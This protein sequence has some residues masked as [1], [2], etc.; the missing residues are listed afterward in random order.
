[1]KSLPVLSCSIVFLTAGI[2][3]SAT[4][5]QA[6]EYKT[7]LSKAE[8]E[9]SLERRLE[10]WVKA[11]EAAEDE[12]KKF[13]LYGKGFSLARK[14]DNTKYISVFAK[15]LNKS[16]L[17]SPA[18]KAS[19]IFEYLSVQKKKHQPLPSKEWED[20]LAMPGTDPK[21]D[22]TARRNLADAYHRDSQW[23]KEIALLKKLVK[24]P[25]ADD[26]KKQDILFNLSQV[27]LAMNRMDDA[28]AC[29]KDVLRIKSL[30]P[31]RRAK[32]HL[33]IASALVH[34][35]GWHSV[36]S[37]ERYKQ[38]SDHCLQAMKAKDKYYYRQALISLVAGTYKIGNDEEVIR[39][40]KKYLTR[41]KKVDLP[42]WLEVKTYETR[43]LLREE[44]YPEAIEIL[45]QLY[46]SRSGPD[47]CISLGQTYYR[48]GDYT[49]ALGM[50]SEA[51]DLLK[52]DDSDRLP[53]SK[54]W[55][56][57][58]GGLVK[59]K[60]QLDALFLARAKRLN[61]EARAAGKAPVAEEREVDE[62]RPFQKKGK[63][64]EPTSLEEINKEEE[65]DLLGEGLDL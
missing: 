58:L 42:T 55:C 31:N 32:V 52:G 40:S 49:A 51:V 26:F 24:H 45:E 17:A 23:Y 59:I 27:Y 44:R 2:F 53:R 4:G 48:N 7:L 14:I 12:S 63:K 39:L 29:L 5:L 54:S 11:A 10:L 16:P 15:L 3:F 61:A 22:F 28:V 6:G 35:Y 46:K 62:L 19:A 36:L 38:M 13:D 43:A 34:G 50:Y 56:Q 20:Y 64:K 18:L 8:N 47:V 1:M 21:N 41:N 33:M 25:E 65:H 9:S 60:P 30:S 37:P 57:R